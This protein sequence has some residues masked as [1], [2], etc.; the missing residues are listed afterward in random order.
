MCSELDYP[1]IVCQTASCYIV[2]EIEHYYWVL[3]SF[4]I[5]VTLRGFPRRR[6]GRD[7]ETCQILWVVASMRYCVR[8]GNP[9]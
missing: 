9:E 8:S 7:F 3:G 1:V 2:I 6:E 4:G 5:T